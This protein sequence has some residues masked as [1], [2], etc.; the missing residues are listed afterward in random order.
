M[1]KEKHRMKH[2]RKRRNEMAADW[3]GTPSSIFGCAWYFH[4]F[5]RREKKKMK[6][7][8]FLYIVVINTKGKK[9]KN[10]LSNPKTKS[11]NATEKT[12]QPHWIV[13]EARR[14]DAIGM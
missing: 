9:T 7:T 5:Q 1:K 13:L 8:A 11:N 6:Q 2:K 3:L 10:L 12:S 14:N 4:K